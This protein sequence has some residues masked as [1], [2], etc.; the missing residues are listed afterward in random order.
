MLLIISIYC[1]VQDHDAVVKVMMLHGG[2]GVE[3]SQGIAFPE[4]EKKKEDYTVGLA[5]TE[6]TFFPLDLKG[7]VGSS[8]VQVMAEAANE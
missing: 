5:I 3:H 7:I 1:A 8:V 6:V 4:R 2:G